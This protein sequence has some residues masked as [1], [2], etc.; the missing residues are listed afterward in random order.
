M[1]ACV[2]SL[3]LAALRLASGAA[4]PA[5]DE[6]CELNVVTITERHLVPYP[7]VTPTPAIP[8]DGTTVDTP[9][10]SA[11]L[12]PSTYVP[13]ANSSTS[14]DAFT[15]YRSIGYFGDWD[16]YARQFFPNM[17]HAEQ[18]THLMLAFW[19]VNSTTG[20]IQ[21]LDREADLLVRLETGSI[22]WNPADKGTVK[23]VVEELYKMKQEYRNLKTMLSVGGWTASSDG[24]FNQYLSTPEARA[25]FASSAAKYIN[26]FGMDG[27]DVDWEYP[28][29]PE[30]GENLADLLR[31]CREELNK[32]GP[33]FEL[34]IAAPCST[35]KIDQLPLMAID[36]S[37]DFWNLM[38]YDFAG[39]GFSKFTG[40]MSNFYP[41]TENPDST[42]FSY[43][44]ALDKY[45]EAGI[46]PRKLVTGLP[47][48]GRSFTN[49]DGLGK[50]FSGMDNSGVEPGVHDFKSLPLSPE[51]EIF[52]DE[53]ILASGSYNPIT[54]TLISYDTPRMAQLKAQFIMDRGLGGAFWWEVSGDSQDSKI[55]LVQTVLRTFGGNSTLQQKESH[56]DYPDSIYSNIR[57]WNKTFVSW[58]R[59][60][61]DS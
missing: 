35:S 30:D 18:F 19:V 58:N 51:D 44:A 8:E 50:P 46:N 48:Y 45:L 23:G 60:D 47:L 52:E 13:P 43:V 32:L 34:S 10:A 5:F 36:E 28:D 31:R 61:F 38:A 7:E 16:I 6:N 53:T 29:T 4:I 26:D 55:N 15:G 56:L 33:G 57:V 1:N 20:E 40:H 21:S 42:D 59:P 24:K 17:I 25:N 3:F 54:R 11:T 14:D 22:V 27:L 2:F 41:S 39:P 49:T 12:A 37:L 9:V